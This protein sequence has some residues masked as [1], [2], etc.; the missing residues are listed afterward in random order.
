MADS[1]IKGLP[2]LKKI[3]FGSGD[4]Y[5]GGGQQLVGFLYPFFLTNL[6]G[7]RPALAGAILI[8]SKAW[9]AISDPL[10][11]V[12]S[13]RTRS[14]LGRRRPYFLAGTVLIFISFASLWLPFRFG[15]Q[16]AKFIFILSVW[17]FHETICS[18]VLVPFYALGADLTSDYNERN[19]IMFYRLFISTISVILVAVLPKIVAGQFADERLGYAL[20][21]AGFGFLFSLPWLAMFFA[22]PERGDTRIDKAVTMRD[23]LVEPLRLKSFRQLMLFFI[24]GYTSVD[25][26]SSIFIYYMTY[27]LQRADYNL[28]LGAMLVGQFLLLPVSL[29][30]AKTIGKRKVLILGDGWWL[31]TV[32]TMAAVTPA[33]PRLILYAI[34]FLMGGGV[35]AAAFIPWAIFPDVADVGELVYGERRDGA[36][37]G[38]L[39]FARKCSTAIAMGFFLLALDVAGYVRPIEKVVN[40]ITKTINQPQPPSALLV[41]RIGL[42]L[43]PACLLCFGIYLAARR[44]KLS[45]EI[46]ARVQRALA[47]QRGQSPTDE[48]A[49]Q[50]VAELQRM[51]AG[52]SPAFR[53]HS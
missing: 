35:G 1:K 3:I 27:Y 11:G 12:I 39:T 32:L 20:M 17:L 44:F 52:E 42:F 34:A 31:L 6:V 21:G 50:E 43:V 47:F 49:A 41:M 26:M 23:Q 28:V 2:L 37:G 53:S 14:R 45:A 9:D 5:A 38:F 18:M 25:L 22:F 7:L 8:I 46:H 24:C 30:L 51:L 4:V 15:T 33:S 16:L 19:S 10:M 13:D 48:L 40:G 36:S 29:L